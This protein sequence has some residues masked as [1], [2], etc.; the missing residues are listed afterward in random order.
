MLHWKLK[1]TH[2]QKD[3]HNLKISTKKRSEFKTLTKSKLKNKLKPQTLHM[4]GKKRR[5]RRGSSL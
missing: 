5:A 3:N 4:I 2:S 1:L